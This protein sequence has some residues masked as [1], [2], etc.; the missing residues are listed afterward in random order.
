M[1]ESS[2]Q[3]ERYGQIKHCTLSQSTWFLLLLYFINFHHL[4]INDNFSGKNLL[5]PMFGIDI[6][7]KELTGKTYR[8][9]ESGHWLITIFLAPD[10]Q[11]QAWSLVTLAYQA[12]P[13]TNLESISHE[14]SRAGLQH[15]KPERQETS[16]YIDFL[17]VQFDCP[18]WRCFF[19]TGTDLW[20]LFCLVFQT[21]KHENTLL[22]KI[23]DINLRTVDNDLGMFGG[24]H[25]DGIYIRFTKSLCLLILSHFWW[26]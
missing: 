15:Q 1:L 7:L 14:T 19:S 11:A 5:I 24:R 12:H 3:Q 9:L 23:G 13:F 25:P 26:L 16:L 17:Q 4:Y 22:K 18:I 10:S 8:L 6:G 21:W 2:K 20:A